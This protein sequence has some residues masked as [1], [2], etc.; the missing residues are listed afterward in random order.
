MIESGKREETL[1]QRARRILRR[2]D[3]WAFERLG[4]AR[5]R[6]VSVLDEGTGLWLTLTPTRFYVI[7]QVGGR[8]YY[9]DRVTG[10]YDGWGQAVSCSA[11]EGECQE[12]AP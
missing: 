3:Q 8:D 9:F 4:I 2:F 11:Q 7:F 12:L 10:H 1:G 5:V 6:C